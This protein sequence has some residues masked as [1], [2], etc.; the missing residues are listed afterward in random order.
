MIVA[1]IPADYHVPPKA[2]KGYKSLPDVGIKGFVAP[3]LGGWVAGSIVGKQA[4]RVSLAGKGASEATT[5]DLL[6]ETMK[7]HSASTSK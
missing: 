4:I 2:A 7:R 6:K 1:V 5:V 3:E